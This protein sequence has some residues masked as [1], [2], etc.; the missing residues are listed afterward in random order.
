MDKCFIRKFDSMQF[1]PAHVH[2]LRTYAF[3]PIIIQEILHF[4]G[5]LLWLDIDQRFL[6]HSSIK[7]YMSNTTSKGKAINMSVGRVE[8]LKK[9]LR[10]TQCNI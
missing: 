10:I 1:Y 2:K 9:K 6:S 8:A 4:S 3:R 5:S 7:L